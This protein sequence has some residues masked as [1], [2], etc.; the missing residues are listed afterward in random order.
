[1]RRWV[2]RLLLAIVIAGTTCGVGTAQASVTLGS[3]LSVAPSNLGSRCFALGGCLELGTV[4]PGRQLVSPSTG[5]ITAWDLRVGAGTE[6][7]SLR[8]RVVRPSGGG[9]TVVS[10]SPL[11]LIPNGAGTY[12]FPAQ[13]AIDSGDQIALEYGHEGNGAFIYHRASHAGAAWEGLGPNPVADGGMTGVVSMGVVDEELTYNAVLVPTSTFSLGAVT[14]HKKKGTATIDV[15]VPNA[16]EL[17]ASGIGARVLRVA[18]ARLSESVDPGTVQFQ[19]RATGK[20]K[21]KLRRTGRAKLRLTFTY[22]PTGGDPSTQ[23]LKVKLKKGH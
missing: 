7:Q 16:G 12:E 11:Q 5:M 10:S 8:I 23:S 2:A 13:L 9:F 20:R 21:R 1:M 22:T 19:V 3:D 18:G 14:R 6:T 15:G 4:I 17:S